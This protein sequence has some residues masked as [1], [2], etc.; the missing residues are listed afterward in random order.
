VGTAREL[1]NLLKNLPLIL[2]S[3][4]EEDEPVWQLTMLL[5]HIVEIVTGPK[6]RP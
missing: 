1:W 2:F 6:T 4:V 5:R 3:D